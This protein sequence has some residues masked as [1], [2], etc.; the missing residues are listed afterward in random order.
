MGSSQS[1]CLHDFI[2]Q[3]QAVARRVIPKRQKQHWS[4]NDAEGLL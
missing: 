2:P 3:Y 1:S 4:K